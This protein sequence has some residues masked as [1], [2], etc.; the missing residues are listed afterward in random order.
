MSI[1]VLACRCQKIK[2]LVVVDL[3]G[4]YFAGKVAFL[5]GLIIYVWRLEIQ[6]GGRP[7]GLKQ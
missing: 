2:L 3:S 4:G 7:A 5:L 1:A 6:L